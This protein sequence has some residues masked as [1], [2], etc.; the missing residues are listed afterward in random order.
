MDRRCLKD[1]ILQNFMKCDL[2][3]STSYPTFRDGYSLR[4]ES[5]SE[6]SSLTVS[7]T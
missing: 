3:D 7:P 4:A 1:L 2:M 6:S 5:H